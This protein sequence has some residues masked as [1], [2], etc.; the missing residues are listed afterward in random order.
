M[1]TVE[2]PLNHYC[3]RF[4]K[5]TYQEEF[6]LEVQ[7]GQDARKIILAAAMVDVSNFLIVDPAHATTVLEALPQTVLDRIWVLYKSG[8]PEDRFF[9]TRGLYRA[10]DPNSVKKIAEDDEDRRSAVVD[11]TLSEME[12]RFGKEEVAE[13]QII[14]Q[15][16]FQDAQRRGVLTKIDPEGVA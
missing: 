8:L 5:L 9:S 10:P 11:R 13:A 7:P 16:L 15:R 4:R 6:G 14:D 12:R 2:V 3:Y 1:Q